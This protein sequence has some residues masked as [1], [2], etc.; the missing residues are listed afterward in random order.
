MKA[1]SKHIFLFA[2]IVLI[3]LA[4]ILW[5]L[6]H[7]VFAIF[8]NIQSHAEELGKLNPVFLIAAIAILPAIGIP[9]S[10]FYML[11]GIVYGI[12]WGLTYSGIGVAINISLCYWITNS[13]LRN[14]IFDFIKRRGHE[15]LE[16][17]PSERSAIIVAI[18]LMPGLPFS[19]QN[20]ILG[21]AGIPFMH[22]FLLSWPTQMVWGV[23]FVLIG[24][25]IIEG[26]TASLVMIVCGIIVLFLLIKILRNMT[27][28]TKMKGS[29]ADDK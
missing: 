9:V 17:P 6:R 12:G 25:A 5:P 29:N 1:W 2:S 10:P 20:Y 4:A 28:K 7:E 16:I 15:P 27:A 24:A 23:I 21:L 3:G 18:R 22:Y 14:W 13:Y 11:G 26:S 19:A 8:Q